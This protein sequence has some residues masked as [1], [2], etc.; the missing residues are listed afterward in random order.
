[1]TDTERIPAAE[2][3]RDR[4]RFLHQ[5]GDFV[6]ARYLGPSGLGG[7]AYIGTIVGEHDGI[8]GAGRYQKV[9]PDGTVEVARA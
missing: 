4:R 6:T 8:G 1:M 3:V 5:S 9:A 7:G 2:A